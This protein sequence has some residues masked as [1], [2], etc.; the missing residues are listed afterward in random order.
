MELE[1]A[2]NYW[3]DP[4]FIEKEGRITLHNVLEYFRQHYEYDKNSK[5][6][7]IANGYKIYEDFE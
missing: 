2:E 3:W 1:P 7:K 6:E 4:A 5:N